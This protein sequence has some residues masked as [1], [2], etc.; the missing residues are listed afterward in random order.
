LIYKLFI[1]IKLY[2]YIYISRPH[3][4]LWQNARIILLTWGQ[5]KVFINDNYPGWKWSSAWLIILICKTNKS[6]ELNF[7]VL[8]K[9]MFNVR[10]SSTLSSGPLLYPSW[11]L[12]VVRS[13]RNR[14]IWNISSFCS[15][16][17]IL[18]YEYF[19][20][21]DIF[22]IRSQTLDCILL[23]IVY[24]YRNIVIISI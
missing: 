14:E 4:Y 19:L 11:C 16:N 17:T 7:V 6:H 23:L 10:K 9:E 24:F 13:E 12:W 2:I 8:M 5:I 1:K 21:L 3:G 18:Q 22:A 15:K 20:R